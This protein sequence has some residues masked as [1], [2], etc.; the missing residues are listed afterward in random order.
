MAITCGGV[1]GGECVASAEVAGGTRAHSRG[2][3][4]GESPGEDHREWHRGL[5]HPTVGVSSPVASNGRDVF[6]CGIQRS[7]CLL[8]WHPTAGVSSPVASYGRGVFSCSIRTQLR[9][10]SCV[11]H[12]GLKGSTPLSSAFTPILSNPNGR[13]PHSTPCDRKRA[14][15]A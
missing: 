10:L 8:L 5:E 14:Q 6:S 12:R 9:P 2:A 13:R 15:Y 1:G 11:Q 4:G 7:E 3:G